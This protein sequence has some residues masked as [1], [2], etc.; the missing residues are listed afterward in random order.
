MTLADFSIGREFM[1]G[2][3]RWRCTD[4]GTRVRVS[5]HTDKPITSAALTLGDGDRVQLSKGKH[6]A[7]GDD[8]KS[9][10]GLPVKIH[11]R[12]SFNPEPGVAAGSALN[13]RVI[14]AKSR[15]HHCT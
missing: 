3:R 11:S 9:G 8:E 15:F 4:V 1:C 10:G 12:L 13:D 2:G 7:D 14:K 6:G 5:V